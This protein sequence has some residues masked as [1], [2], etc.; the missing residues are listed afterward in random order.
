M[1]KFR[2][3]DIVEGFDMPIEIEGKNDQTWIYPTAEWKT[4]PMSEEDIK[5]DRDYYI[6]SKKL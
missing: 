5:I 2:Y 3:V 6:Y 1:L 4:I